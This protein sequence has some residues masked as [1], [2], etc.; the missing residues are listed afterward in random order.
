VRMRD[1]TDEEIAAYI[2]SGDPFDKA[3]AYAVQHPEFQPVAEIRGCPLNV[4]G[5]SLCALRARFDDPDGFGKC[6]SVC[7]AWFG[8]ACPALRNDPQHRVSGA[9]RQP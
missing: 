6:G 1:Y 4:I 3:G 8:T 2:A 7:E 5:L 9:R